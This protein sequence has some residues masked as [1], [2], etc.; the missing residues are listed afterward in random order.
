MATNFNVT[1][2]ESTLFYNATDEGINMFGIPLKYLRAVNKNKDEILGEFQHQIYDQSTVYDIY[3]MLENKISFDGGDL[4]SKFGIAMQDSM[5][6]FVSGKTFDDLDFQPVAGDI[7]Y[8]S[9]SNAALEVIRADNETEESGFYTGGTTMAWKLVT[10][11]YTYDSD[12]FSTGIEKIDE[13]IENLKLNDAE[14]P[15]QIDD[16]INSILDSDEKSPWE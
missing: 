11:K 4:Y 2:S 10:R 5:N 14:I 1:S 9:A 7:V 3:G 15:T 8:W 13:T 6:I 16:A 12:I